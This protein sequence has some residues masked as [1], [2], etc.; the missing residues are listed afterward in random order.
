MT[1]WG[2]IIFWD[3]Q[4]VSA[5]FVIKFSQ[6]CVFVIS[7]IEG[8]FA[9]GEAENQEVDQPDLHLEPQPTIPI[10]GPSTNRSGSP[11]AKDGAMTQSQYFK[12]MLALE[13]RKVK[14][15]ENMLSLKRLYYSEKLKLMG[16][17]LPDQDF[18]DAL[19]EAAN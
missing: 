2:C 6:V 8:G 14:I 10:A 13:G 18:F 19:E 16:A 11:P 9:S 15:M 1:L 4:F 12:G 5:C 3:A 17:K 7:G